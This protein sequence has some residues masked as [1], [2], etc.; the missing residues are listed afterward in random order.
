MHASLSLAIVALLALSGCSYSSSYV[1]PQDGRARLVWNDKQVVPSLP[2]VSASCSDRVRV[3]SLER[4]PMEDPLAPPHV[5]WQPPREPRWDDEE[6]GTDARVQI[7]I[8]GGR[9]G[10][11]FYGMHHGEARGGRGGARIG[12]AGRGGGRGGAG[13]FHG[14]K[15]GKG[16]LVVVALAYLIVPT[17]VAVWAGQRPDQTDVAKGMDQVH[18]FNDLARSGDPACVGTP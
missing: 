10:R 18:A 11:R 12:A 7:D 9:G 17:V 8:N 2:S 14:G 4:S 13:G 6:A 5:W 15:L 1:P 3:T 16:A